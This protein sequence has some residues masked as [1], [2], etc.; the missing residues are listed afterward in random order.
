MEYY[1]AGK[2]E[3]SGRASIATKKS[4]RSV[5]F[6]KQVVEDDATAAVCANLKTY[7]YFF[8]VEF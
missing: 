6:Q 3:G 7:N 2:R 5:E 8:C 1:T 4:Q